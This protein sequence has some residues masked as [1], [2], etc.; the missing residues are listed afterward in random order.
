MDC[1]FISLSEILTIKTVDG[2]KESGLSDAEAMRY[3]V[4]TFFA[5]AFV[6]HLI[7]IVVS[8]IMQASQQVVKRRLL[9]ESALT[10]MEIEGW[11]RSSRRKAGWTYP[12]AGCEVGISIFDC[13]CHNPRQ[14]DL[15]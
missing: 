7:D 2:F 1:R 5:G 12:R 11:E 14:S 13:D 3:A 15:C 10:R 4:F 9:L 8:Y 6:C